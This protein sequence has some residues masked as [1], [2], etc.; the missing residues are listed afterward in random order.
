MIVR[1]WLMSLID[2]KYLDALLSCVSSVIS[3]LLSWCDGLIQF[4]GIQYNVSEESNT[5]A[6]AELNHVLLRF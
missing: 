6:T 2:H 3:S 4:V 5:D 1:A